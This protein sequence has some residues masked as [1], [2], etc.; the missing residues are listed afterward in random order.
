MTSKCWCLICTDWL[1]FESFIY[2]TLSVILLRVND[3]KSTFNLRLKTTCMVS[4]L[5]PASYFSYEDV[6][7]IVMT[8]SGGSL[9]VCDIP[10]ITS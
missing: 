6:C 3:K 1:R 8:G 10:F 4:A 7:T 2:F 5:L 9:G